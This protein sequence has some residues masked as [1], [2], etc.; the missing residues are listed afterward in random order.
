MNVFF[1]Y[2]KI[3]LLHHI[4][5]FFVCLGLLL[6]SMQIYADSSTN[7]KE[8]CSTHIHKIQITP[9]NS[10]DNNNPP[11]QGWESVEKFPH[12]WNTQWP[13]FVNSVWY[14][15]EW[16]HQ[17][18]N[19]V[20]AITLVIENLN[21]AGEIYINHDLL[22]RSTS[23][24]EPFSRHLLTPMQWTIPASSL[25]NGSNTFYIYVQG[26]P[27]QNSGIGNFYLKDDLTAK[28]IHKT[29][30]LQKQT[31][32]VFNLAINL[33]IALFCF[34]VWVFYRKETA[35]FWFSFL[36]FSWAIYLSMAMVSEPWNLFSNLFFDKFQIF[37]FCCYVS[38]GCLAIWRFAGKKYP[39]IEKSL[40]LFCIC[41]AIFIF[42][43]PADLQPII[44][45][46]F[47][48][49]A[50]AIFLIKA[51][52]YPFV[53]Y[54]TKYKEAYVL[55]YIQ[56]IYF[57]I[58]INDAHYML[59][60]EGYI[61]S[62]YTAP[63]SSLFI[64]FVLALRLASN[65]KRIESFNKT[66]EESI[67]E[68]KKELTSS[69]QSK[70][71]LE[72]E[73]AKLQE[74]INLSHDLHDGLGGSIVRSMLYLDHN[75]DIKKDQMMSILKL[76]RSDLRQVI[77][78]GSSLNSKVADSPILWVAPLR[79]RFIQLFEEMNIQS[80]WLFSPHWKE[81]P[82]P[83]QALT[84]ARVAEEA[85]NNI[86][87]HSQAN[88]VTISLTETDDPSIVLEIKDNGIGFDPNFIQE[89]LHVGLHSMLVRVQRVGGFLEITSQ[90]NESVIKVTF[91]RQK[92]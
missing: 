87:K 59:T 25:R 31:L 26:V 55:V 86:V 17:C 84:L 43:S 9:A 47:F 60:N 38:L 69:L 4:S 71:Q 72:L 39:K 51:L 67:T 56:L 44:Q 18:A 34:M 30:V 19:Q 54:K 21:L 89:G 27:T 92:V 35:F 16:H 91:F 41:S 61:L 66:L 79:H 13:N 29:L 63:I 65:T 81:V 11:L 1:E 36:G 83:L 6:C 8:Q 53:A 62:P 2:L 37:I 52:T 12:Y 78:F 15:I 64:G 77:D 45:K 68:T 80:T 7:T 58:A 5:S 49:I 28:S 48:I 23:L 24:N 20:Q 3:H 14:K 10:N 76:L 88:Q 22:W 70:Y 90:P 74:R 33:I 85:L 50:V 82:Q 40:G 42:L 73:N 32:N 46:V 75:N 57:P